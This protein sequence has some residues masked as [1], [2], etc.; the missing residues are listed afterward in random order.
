MVLRLISSIKYGEAPFLSE[1]FIDNRGV[2]LHLHRAGT[3]EP[4]LFLHGVQGMPDWPPALAHLAGHFDVLAPDHPGFGRS[5]APDWIDDVPDLGFF[6]LD[7]L[8]A[9]DLK[10][11]HLVGVSLGGW[12]AMEMAIRS[13]AR[14]K[15]LTLA[16]A[17]GIRVAGVARGDMFICPPADLGRL[18]FAEEAVAARWAAQWQATPELQEIYD[19]N[20]SAAA[21]YTWQPRLYNPLLAK[22]LHRIDVPVHIIWGEQDRLIPPAH[23]VA[24]K[25]LIPRAAVTMVPGGHLLPIEQPGLFATTVAT[26]IERLRP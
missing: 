8:D 15:S 18:L 7:L 20:R 4:L 1:T 9:L 23:A 5:D 21:K 13:T 22:W 24:L 25:E 6:Y 10:G 19:K 17:A 12:I 26:F 16:D 3:G 11:V 2:K 14:I